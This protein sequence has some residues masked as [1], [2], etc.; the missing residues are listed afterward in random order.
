META[1]NKKQILAMI[2]YYQS[3]HHITCVQVSEI[4]QPGKEDWCSAS[5]FILRLMIESRRGISCHRQ[6]CI[7]SARR[8]V[9]TLE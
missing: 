3:S 1:E 4:L 6:I 7:F 9:F 2:G 5:I 8:H